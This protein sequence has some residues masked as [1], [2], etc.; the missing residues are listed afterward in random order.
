MTRFWASARLP[1]AMAAPLSSSGNIL[2]IKLG[3]L[4]DFVQALGPMRAI[5]DHHAGQRIDLLTTPPFEDLASATGLFDR[6]I[7]QPRMKW[8]QLGALCALRRG[9][10][11][12]GYTRVYDLQT[13]DR[14]S[15]YFRLFPA[16]TRPEWSGI[17][18]GCSH[19]HANPE[20]DRMHTVERQADQ[21]AMAGIPSVPAPDL[22]FAETD[23]SRFALPDAFALIVPGGAAHRPAKRWPADRFA[24]LARHLSG[25]GIT[26]LLIGG[27]D[28]R[29]LHDAILAAAPGARS[30][31]GETSLLDLAALARRAA[32]AVGNDTGPM[33]VAALAGAPTVVLYSHASDPAL[34]AQRGA[35]VTILREARLSDLTLE[36]VLKVL[37]ALPLPDP[38]P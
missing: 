16:R 14:S 26:P 9:L 38:A 1:D 30:L 17:A 7:A 28:E 27:A 2:V 25:Q 37:P 4:G 18:R 31:C 29:A 22:S 23:L 5:R 20:R 19:P 6:V 15:F 34:C 10:I 35:Q 36:D 24:A 8:H 21:L 33:H 32:L 3:A 13:S 12:G 11:Q